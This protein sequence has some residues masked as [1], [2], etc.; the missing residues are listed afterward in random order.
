MIA[1]GVAATGAGRG[2]LVAGLLGLLDFVIDDF[3]GFR[4]PLGRGGFFTDLTGFLR[5]GVG[6]L[7]LLDLATEVGFLSAKRENHKNRILMKFCQVCDARP[8]MACIL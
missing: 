7:V 2:D 8:I 3:T 1:G 5:L 4:E 6:R